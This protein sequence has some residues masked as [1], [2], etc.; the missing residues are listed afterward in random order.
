MVALESG[1]FVDCFKY[2]TIDYRQGILP[3]WFDFGEYLTVATEC[4]Q[5]FMIDFI[6]NLQK[7]FCIFFLYLF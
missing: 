2:A 7:Q 5:I 4:G 1:G 3:I 6:M